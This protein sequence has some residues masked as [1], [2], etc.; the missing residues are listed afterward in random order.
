MTLYF[1]DEVDEDGTFVEIRDIVDEVIPCD[2]Y[3]DETL[4]MSMSQI[5]GTIQLELASPFDL[6][7][8]SAIKIAE[9]IQIAPASEFSE[10]VIFVDDLFESTVSPVKGASDFVDSPLSFD[11]LSRFVSRSDNVHDSSSMDLSIFLVSV[12][13]LWYYFIGTLFT[14]ITDICYK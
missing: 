7:K 12:R 9:E 11:V 5:D 2:E 13:L 3:I 4:T 8:V 6:F 14:H 1:P 10:D